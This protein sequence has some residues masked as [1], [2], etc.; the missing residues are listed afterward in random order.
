MSSVCRG[1]GSAGA[2]LNASAPIDSGRMR[3]APS[4]G[5]CAR[6]WQSIAMHQMSGKA[7]AASTSLPAS[8]QPRPAR[9]RT[10]AA[11]RAGGAGL[12][13]RRLRCA[14]CS[15]QSMLVSCEQSADNGPAVSTRSNGH[16]SSNRCRRGKQIAVPGL[17]CSHSRPRISKRIRALTLLG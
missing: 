16:L 9:P 7:P 6:C 8:R 12:S 17:V 4:A 5:P 15:H 3:P 2:P 10:C 11:C 14:P 1:G 13:P